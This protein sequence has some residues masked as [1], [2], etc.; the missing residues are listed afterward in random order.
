MMDALEEAYSEW[1]NSGD[2]LTIQQHCIDHCNEKF[3]WEDKRE[4]LLKVFKDVEKV[5]SIRLAN[6]PLKV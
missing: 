1:Q 6:K 2:E 3:M 4:D 5:E